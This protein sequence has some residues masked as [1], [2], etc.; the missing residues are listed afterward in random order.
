MSEY[1]DVGL[2]K[3]AVLRYLTKKAINTKCGVESDVITHE[4][5]RDCQ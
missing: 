1:A 4:P 3:V 2:I 5:C